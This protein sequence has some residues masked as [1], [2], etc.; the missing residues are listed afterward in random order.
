[1]RQPVGLTVGVET[2]PTQAAQ[3]HEPCVRGVTAMHSA[4]DEVVV[5]NVRTDVHCVI[6]Y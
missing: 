4:T 1:M 2:L 3:Q 6:A 5:V